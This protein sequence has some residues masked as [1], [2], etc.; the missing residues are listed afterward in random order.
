MLTYSEVWNKCLA[1]LREH[2][3]EETI[4]TWFIPIVPKSLEDNN[5]TIEVPSSFFYEWISEHYSNDILKSL[6]TVCENSIILNYIIKDESKESNAKL[7]KNN[8][9]IYK[10]LQPYSDFIKKNFADPDNIS[11]LNPNYTFD[12]FIEGESN[13]L[14]KS[15]AESV[16]KKPLNNP[17]NP[18][19][20]YGE[21]GLGKTHLLHAIGNKI[22][23]NFKDSIVVYIQSTVFIDM[24]ISSIRN[25]TSQEFSGFFSN[26]D[27]LLLDDV[28]FLK[29]KIKTQ[30]NLFYIFNQLHQIGKQIVLT[31][32]RAPSDLEGLQD[33][34]VS[35][36]KWGLTADINTPELET[37][38]AIL[39]KK[40]NYNN[41]I[42]NYILEYI[43]QRV[44]SNIRELEGVMLTAIANVSFGHNMNANY[45][46]KIIN[47]ILNNDIEIDRISFIVAEYFKISI[48]DILGKSRQKDIALA[49]HLVMYFAKKYTECSLNTIGSL[50]GN[51]DHSTVTHAINNVESLLK[52][53]EDIKKI[54]EAINKEIVKKLKQPCKK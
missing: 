22:K 46:Q 41:N 36:F 38:I 27:V 16:A 23:E 11:G 10:K 35:R 6:S 21:V 20:I 44:N 2:I 51:R 25:N 26:I 13:Q 39:K 24:Y 7:D 37:K 30:E 1:L 43:A 42:P 34:L 17:F 47:K 8:K 28:Q 5:F 53:K 33:R 31:S 9:L 19:M 18:L 49:R 40:F 50:I 4:K 32:D 29:D 54:I 45:I 52:N 3:D 14:A 12:N 48:D 15:S